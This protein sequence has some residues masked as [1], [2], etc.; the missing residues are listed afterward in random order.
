MNRIENKEMATDAAKLFKEEIRE[1][2]PDI[3]RKELCDMVDDYIY[4]Q[5]DDVSKEEAH[6]VVDVTCRLALKQGW[7]CSPWTPFWRESSSMAILHDIRKRSLVAT[8]RREKC[9]HLT[10]PRNTQIFFVDR[11]IFSPV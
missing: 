8:G 7:G 9:S 2:M 4:Y 10:S 6:A 5:T 3:P 11:C 1:L